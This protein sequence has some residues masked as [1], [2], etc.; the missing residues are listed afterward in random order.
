MKLKTEYVIYNNPDFNNI[1]SFN[2]IQ[3]CINKAVEL[4]K[5]RHVIMVTVLWT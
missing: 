1:L 4:I 3:D 5:L 2:C